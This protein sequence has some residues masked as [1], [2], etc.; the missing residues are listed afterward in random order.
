MKTFKRLMVFFIFTAV[1]LFSV[2]AYATPTPT[3]A[4]PAIES[5][6]N[7]VKANIT[8]QLLTEAN[9][10]GISNLSN[11]I[12]YGT[13]NDL[14]ATFAVAQ[15]LEA[16]QIADFERG[17]VFV[18]FAYIKATNISNIPAGYYRIDV[19]KNLG[20]DTGYAY[21]I[22]QYGR[23]YTFTITITV[24]VYIPYLVPTLCIAPNYVVLDIHWR[25][26][27]ITIKIT[28]TTSVPTPTPTPRTYIPTPTITPFPT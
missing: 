1:L 4:P 24:G 17:P 26:V 22:D 12:I 7:Y 13:R 8:N 21:L 15:N 16:Y 28:M 10:R 27:V 6:D 20:S 3:P 9:R 14:F 18:G 25:Y 19:Q 11:R 5:L 2:N 23:R